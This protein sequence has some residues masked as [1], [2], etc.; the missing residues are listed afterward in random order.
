MICVYVDFFW[1]KINLRLDTKG[2]LFSKW[3]FG[4]VDFLQTTNDFVRFLEEI[5][6]LQNHFEINWPLSSGIVRV[7][8]IWKSNYKAVIGF[9]DIWDLGWFWAG[10]QY[11]KKNWGQSWATFEGVFNVFWGKNN[12]N[13]FKKYCSVRSKKLHTTY[14]WTIYSKTFRDNREKNMLSDF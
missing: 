5:D 14:L 12:L 10:W 1:I 8:W 9:R 4:I 2:Q 11:W 13:F 3:F 7:P 6:D